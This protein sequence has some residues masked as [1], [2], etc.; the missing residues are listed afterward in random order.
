MLY[1][2]CN[3]NAIVRALRLR[4]NGRRAARKPLKIPLKITIISRQPEQAR[5]PI[6][7]REI[8]D[9]DTRCRCNF[10]EGHRDRAGLPPRS[11]RFGSRLSSLPRH[12]ARLAA[13][14]RVWRRSAGIPGAPAGNPRADEPPVAAYGRR[15]AMATAWR[16]LA[17]ALGK[18]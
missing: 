7:E 2:L 16:G 9:D 11:R 13:F 4:P 5:F 17:P 1:R 10:T 14:Q 15:G 8:P 18:S 12:A 6:A 3:S